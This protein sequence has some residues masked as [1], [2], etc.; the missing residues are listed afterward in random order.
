MKNAKTLDQI[1]KI[2]K[3]IT[4]TKALLKHQMMQVIKHGPK[5]QGL[6]YFLE[7]EP[8]IGKTS[9]ISQVMDEVSEEL[10]KMK[11]DEVYSPSDLAYFKEHQKNK[12]KA[13]T[14]NLCAKDAQDLSGMPVPPSL[15]NGI[16]VQKFSKPDSNPSFG[17]GA[18][19]YDE[20]N[21]TFDIQMVGAL[22]SMWMDRGINGNQLGQGYVQIAAG[23]N[24]DDSR[25]KTSKPDVALQG[26]YRIIHVKPTF[27]EIYGYLEN[28]HKTHFM[29]DY[30]K[31][32]KEICSLW[33][34]PD[35]S[36]SPRDIDN[37]MMITH[38][39]KDSYF[40]NEESKFVIDTNLQI[41]FG[42]MGDKI[43]QVL[44]EKMDISLKKLIEKPE[45]L[46]KVKRED[47]PLM[48]QLS[49]EILNFCAEK[50]KKDD[51]FMK[52]EAQMIEKLGD[53][54]N[55][56]SKSLFLTKLYKLEEKLIAKTTKVMKDSVPEFLK[57]L[58]DVKEVWAANQHEL[59]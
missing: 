8:G 35:T 55:Q 49:L 23:N 38:S 42:S 7:G 15:E 58:Q 36:F 46:K 52:K 30:L 39:V 32:H 6:M 26:R 48:R 29:L 33:G 27:S 13:H 56:E 10:M 20:A 43:I 25:F 24:F 50:A 17:Y 19:F 5:Y 53:V 16:Y 57:G 37:L 1:T 40:E 12:A 14:V 47:L 28:K 3:S 45:L 59:D 2:T 51:D 31:D 54:L 9:I 11:P 22:L 4:E 21:R 44:N 41:Y 18:V 34:D